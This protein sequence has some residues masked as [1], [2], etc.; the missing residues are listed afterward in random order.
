MT[1]TMHDLPNLSLFRYQGSLWVKVG[2]D[3][4]QDHILATP[5]ATQDPNVLGRPW[6]RFREGRLEHQADAFNAYHEWIMGADGIA[7]VI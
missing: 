4:S 2:D 1:Q 3:L 7:S 5:V 6:L